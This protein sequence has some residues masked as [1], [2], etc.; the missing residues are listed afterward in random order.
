MFP[1][2]SYDF[3]SFVYFL[4]GDTQYFEDNIINFKLT[5]SAFDLAVLAA[6]K[7]VALILISTTLETYSY[8]LIDSPF[9]RELRRP[10]IL[11]HIAIK[12]IPFGCLV[13]SIVKGALVLNAVLNDP[14]YDPM[15]APIYA[16]CI[17]FLCL[18]AIEFAFAL[19]SG[20]AMRKLQQV[21][22][23]HQFNDMGQ[24]LDS[25]GRVIQ[26]TPS[27]LKLFSLAKEVSFYDGEVTIM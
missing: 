17:S 9:N 20:H 13:F 12:V 21:R 22:I 1:K 7:A 16:V 3:Y 26:K 27:L 15:P 23:L 25:N 11:L 6:F 2:K 4:G 24:E 18:T 19:W 8:R 14:E 10:V 5:Q